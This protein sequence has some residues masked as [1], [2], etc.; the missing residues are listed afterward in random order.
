[1]NILSIEMKIKILDIFEESAV[2]RCKL[3]FADGTTF[4]NM[5]N[6][7]VL[8]M[9]KVEEGEEVILCYNDTTGDL[10]KNG[11]LLTTKS[12]YW[13]SIMEGVDF[14]SISEIEQIYAKSGRLLTSLMIGQKNGISKEFQVTEPMKRDELERFAQM[15]NG[16]IGILRANIS[17]EANIEPEVRGLGQEDFKEKV[18]GILKR[19]YVDRILLFDDIPLEELQR[20]RSK[21]IVPLEIG[22]KPILHFDDKFPFYFTTGLFLTNTHLRVRGWRRLWSPWPKADVVN[23][24]FDFKGISVEKKGIYSIFIIQTNRNDKSVIFGRIVNRGQAESLAELL[25]Q[26]IHLV[27]SQRG[28]F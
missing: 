13:K 18:R 27:K 12:L 24:S 22:E 20:T 10:P 5:K 23:L 6:A 11:L 3:L 1:M 21:Y 9:Q 19:N 25:N 26:V 14:V 28:S 16:M 17:E 4:L 2:S 8:Y 15:L 7:G